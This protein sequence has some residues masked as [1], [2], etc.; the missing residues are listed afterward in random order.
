ML[1]QNADRA[2]SVSI[3]ARSFVNV[4]CRGNDMRDR[5]QPFLMSPVP[6]RPNHPPVDPGHDT[7]DDPDD[8][9]DT[10]PTE[11]EPVPI[12]DPKPDGQPEGP[13]VA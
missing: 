5:L 11:P 6:D 13:Y 2:C 3:L 12:R 8:V 10:P 1:S 4:F 9:P 7:P